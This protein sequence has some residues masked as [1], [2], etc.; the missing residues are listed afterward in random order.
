MSAHI[1]CTLSGQQKVG[2]HLMSIK[3]L[4]HPTDEHELTD[5][6]GIDHV[7]FVGGGILQLQGGVNQHQVVLWAE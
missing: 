7:V 3:F 2:Q 5:G 6:V 4:N 1:V